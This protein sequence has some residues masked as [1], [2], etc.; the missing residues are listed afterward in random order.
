M[1][2]PCPAGK[3]VME[4]TGPW[5]EGSKLLCARKSTAPLASSSCKVF[6]ISLRQRAG[7]NTT[8]SCHSQVSTYILK[9]KL[10]HSQMDKILINSHHS[11]LCSWEASK[12]NPHADQV[13]QTRY[14]KKKAMGRWKESALFIDRSNG[15]LVI[16]QTDTA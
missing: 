13:N 6:F 7:S 2:S 12:S 9:I 11:S 15:Q 10:I 4:M 3:R 16:F 5:G 14:R 1:A 8:I